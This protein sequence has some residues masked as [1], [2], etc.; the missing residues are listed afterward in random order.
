[1][2]N[3]VESPVLSNSQT[4]ELALQKK[5]TLKLDQT[6]TID[7]AELYYSPAHSSIGGIILSA[8]K[9][10]FE[11]FVPGGD[12][13]TNSNHGFL[14]QRSE[15]IGVFAKF[16]GWRKTFGFLHWYPDKRNWQ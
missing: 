15:V 1:M 13:R 12:S 16:K 3:G 7:T 11:L 14:P 10:K 9:D 2:T 6:K 8:K 5:I 4:S